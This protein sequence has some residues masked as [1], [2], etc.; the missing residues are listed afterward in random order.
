MNCSTAAVL[1]AVIRDV[2]STGA[3]VPILTVGATCSIGEST[4]FVTLTSP[5]GT[6]HGFEDR[7]TDA[8]VDRVA[9]VADQVQ[10]WII[11][12]LAAAGRPTNWP[13]CS[14]H[15]STHPLVAAIRDDVA[16]WIC[17]KIGVIVAEIGHVS[18]SDT[19]A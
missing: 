12:E 9:T 19:S 8:V 15:P 18:I 13:R 5:D 7:V 11:E 6:S 10:E 17:P 16:V 14:L 2:N 1:D 3:P 4:G